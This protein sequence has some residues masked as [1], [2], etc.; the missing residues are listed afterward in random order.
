MINESGSPVGPILH[1]EP[2]VQHDFGF[3]PDGLYIIHADPQ[4]SRRG[5][6]LYNQW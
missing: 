3:Q 6:R 5:V 1:D 4:G 2:G